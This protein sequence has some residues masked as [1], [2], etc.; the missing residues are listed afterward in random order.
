MSDDFDPRFDPAFQRG[1]DGTADAERSPARTA[2]SAAAPRAHPAQPDAVS[3][4]Y[5]QRQPIA[6]SQPV[7]QPQPVDAQP[8]VVAQ[9]GTATSF[10]EFVETA[11][12]PNP[13]LV[14]LV[15]LSVALVGGGLYLVMRLPGL[16]ADAQSSEAIDFATLQVLVEAA[17]IAISLG[18]AT[19]AGVLFVFATRWDRSRAS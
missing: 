6:R 10:D 19:A 5:F 18:V 4:P 12:R 8:R 17:P 16:A 11:R 15:L 3:Q 9:D 13:F 7:A 14:A 2:T 1:Y